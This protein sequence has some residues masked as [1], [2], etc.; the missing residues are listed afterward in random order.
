MKPVRES[1]L[2]CESPHNQAVSCWKPASEALPTST[3]MYTSLGLEGT[4]QV[5]AGAPGRCLP[6]W[7]SNQAG[8]C[9]PEMRVPATWGF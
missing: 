5:L 7:A 2:V 1:A 3:H 8:L 4:T 9:L 6:P